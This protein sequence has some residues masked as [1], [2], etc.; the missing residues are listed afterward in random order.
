MFR[1]RYINTVIAKSL[2]VELGKLF[3]V[4]ALAGL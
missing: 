2:G 4:D 3:R 1:K